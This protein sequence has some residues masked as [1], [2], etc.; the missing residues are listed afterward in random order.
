MSK[1]TKAGRHARRRAHHV[2][3]AREAIEA[4]EGRKFAEW[5][6]LMAPYARGV[7]ESTDQFAAAVRRIFP[8]VA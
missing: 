2:E 3:V 1:H 7:G 5:L 8:G 6:G 4:H